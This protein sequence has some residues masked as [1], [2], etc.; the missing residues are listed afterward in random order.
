MN[1]GRFSTT[2]AVLQC[3]PRAGRRPHIG[4]PLRNRYDI[5]KLMILMRF[6][7]RG[8]RDGADRTRDRGGRS[9]C[10]CMEIEGS[11][12]ATTAARGAIVASRLQPSGWFAT[13]EPR[14]ICQIPRTM[15]IVY[16]QGCSV[17]PERDNQLSYAR[18]SEQCRRGLKRVLRISRIPWLPIGTLARL[19]RCSTSTTR[20]YASPGETRCE[21][22]QPADAQPLKVA[23][24]DS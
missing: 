13:N 21:T 6:W 7:V 24:H 23:S 22:R 8:R 5:R 12:R 14:R 2:G 9:R 17:G 16:T 10:A 1:I 15:K 20:L 11:Y 4:D 3:E 18:T 19:S